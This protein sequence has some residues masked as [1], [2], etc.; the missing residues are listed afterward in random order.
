MHS[1]LTGLQTLYKQ[2]NCIYEIYHRH[3]H[4]LLGSPRTTPTGFHVT[5]CH[6]QRG[7]LLR[8]TRTSAPI[9]D[10]I[11]LSPGSPW[12]HANCFSLVWYCNIPPSPP[13]IIWSLQCQAVTH[14]FSCNSFRLECDVWQGGSRNH[15]STDFKDTCGYEKTEGSGL[16]GSKFS[17]LLMS[18]WIRVRF[19]L[20]V[21]KYL[22]CCTFSRHLLPIFMPWFCPAFWW[23]D[24]NIYLVL[25]A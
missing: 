1:I 19:L 20:V 15:H 11:T 25:S 24:S 9:G 18:S 17:L 22:N 4:G 8:H 13:D 14:Y 21:P 23:R 5:R 6:H 3:G 16:N 7:Q 10:S 2:N 12:L